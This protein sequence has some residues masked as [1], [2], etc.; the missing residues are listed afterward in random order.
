MAQGI[1]K[2]FY[3]PSQ[4]IDVIWFVVNCCVLDAVDLDFT[5]DFCL[6]FEITE[7]LKLMSVSLQ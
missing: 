4:P 3:N 6:S 5:V 2:Y 7:T 1:V